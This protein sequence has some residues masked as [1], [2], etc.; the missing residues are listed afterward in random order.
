VVWLGLH[1]DGPKKKID[2]GDMTLIFALNT[3]KELYLASDGIGLYRTNDGLTPKFIPVEK[4]IKV[5]DN[6]EILF[7][8]VLDLARRYYYE[9]QLELW[10]TDGIDEKW[11]CFR[12]AKTLEKFIAPTYARFERIYSTSV[13]SP[14]ILRMYGTVS[15]FLRMDWPLEIFV[16]GMDKDMGS[17]ISN[18]QIY[19]L[20][21]NQKY[22]AFKFNREIALSG[23]P[24]VIKKAGLIFDESRFLDFFNS[25]SKIKKEI[26]LCYEELIQKLDNECSDDKIVCVDEPIHIARINKDGYKLLR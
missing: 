9:A 25:P 18:P 15:A 2:A 23:A 16:C 19:I 20:N 4:F 17:N 8:G 13:R 6:V 7:S 10:E 26:E 5:N 1:G 3:G 14:E 12:L 21:N 24:N 11:S 22:I